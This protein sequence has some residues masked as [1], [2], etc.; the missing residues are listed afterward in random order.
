MKALSMPP[1]LTLPTVVALLAASHAHAAPHVF[2]LDAT[3]DGCAAT[4]RDLAAPASPARVLF[5]SK[6]KECPREVL[7]GKVFIAVEGTSVKAYAPDGKVTEMAT[8]PAAN[9]NVWVEEGGKVR[10]AWLVTEGVTM[11]E[12]GDAM[13]FEGKP[14]K[15]MDGD[16]PVV[17]P[18]GMPAMALLAEL[19]G[20]G[21]T[22]T[23]K[24]IEA[25][26]TKTEA[27][28]TPGLSALRTPKTMKKGVVSIGDVVATMTCMGSLECD[29][30]DA[31]AKKL[32]GA[33]DEIELGVLPLQG[34][35][36]V[37]PVMF[38]DTPHATPPVY[39]CSDS[40]A[41]CKK[42]VLIEKKTKDQRQLGFAAQG[43]YAIVSEE[44]SSSNARVID[45]SGKTI[46]S[47]PTSTSVVFL[48]KGFALP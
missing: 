47:L 11:S 14:F 28:D 40:A 44:Y 7:L 12:K 35:A 31:A 43:D 3:K 36:L 33:T 37:F 21:A 30:E 34:G 4:V 24:R 15:L 23:W 38:G 45:A 39:L 8:L 16:V 17:P 46:L 5:T 2:S 9:A 19:E 32:V 18:W 13:T 1:L 41:L 27:G 22:A 26:P 48:P 42:N 20:A 29:R 10:A 25:R 6:A